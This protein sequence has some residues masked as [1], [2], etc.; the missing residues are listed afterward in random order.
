MRFRSRKQGSPRCTATFAGFHRRVPRRSGRTCRVRHRCSL[1]RRGYP[2]GPARRVG[3][4]RDRT[5]NSRSAGFRK[6]RRSKRWTHHHIVKVA[7]AI[8]SLFEHAEPEQQQDRQQPDNTTH[9]PAD[10]RA[11]IYTRRISTLSLSLFL[12]PLDRDSLAPPLPLLGSTVPTTL[13]CAFPL[14]SVMVTVL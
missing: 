4:V 3:I 12:V 14:E 6:S 9:R 13:S 11:D 7:L 1:R 8:P 2:S 5:G 10:D